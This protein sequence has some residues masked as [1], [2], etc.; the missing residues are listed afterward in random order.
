MNYAFNASPNTNQPSSDQRRKSRFRPS[1]ASP[2]DS[3][4]EYINSITKASPF[5]NKRLV[6]ANLLNLYKEV[7]E[8]PPLA[9][10]KEI[11]QAPEY[12]IFKQYQKVVYVLLEQPTSS[13]IGVFIFLLIVSAILIEVGEAIFNNSMANL[14][15]LQALGIINTN[16]TEYTCSRTS[17]LEFSVQPLFIQIFIEKGLSSPYF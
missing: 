4:E 14:S 17:Y 5:I 11:P 1:V 9:D 7:K 2:S 12:K 16:H 8:F 6:V 10:I 13:I 3:K 15:R